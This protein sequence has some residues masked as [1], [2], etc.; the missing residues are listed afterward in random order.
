MKPSIL[1]ALVNS[2]RWV[3]ENLTPNIRVHLTDYNGFA[4]FRSQVMRG[5]NAQ[6]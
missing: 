5:V 3:C 1:G 2:L 6:G 4:P